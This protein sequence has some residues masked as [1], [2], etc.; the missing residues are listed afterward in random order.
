MVLAKHHAGGDVDDLYVQA[1]IIAKINFK[2]RHLAPSY[3]QLLFGGEWRRLWIGV[4]VVSSHTYLKKA[5]KFTNIL[6]S[7]FGKSSLAS[8]CKYAGSR[9]FLLANSY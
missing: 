1:K 4:G 2:K 6:L 5:E 8:M 3:F 9:I 7:N